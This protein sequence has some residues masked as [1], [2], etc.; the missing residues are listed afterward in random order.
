MLEDVFGD[1]DDNAADEDEDEDEDDVLV[2]PIPMVFKDDDE[3]FGK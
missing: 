3:V 2:G 1:P